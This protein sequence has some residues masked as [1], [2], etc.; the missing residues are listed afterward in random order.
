M[1]KEPFLQVSKR[2]NKARWQ[3]RLLDVY[4]RQV[5]KLLRDD[6]KSYQARAEAVRTAQIY[7]ECYA[8]ARCPSENLDSPTVIGAQAANELLN[9]AG[10]KASFV[11]TQYNNEVYISARAI[12]EVNVQ[13]MMEKMGGG[14]HMNIAGAQVKAS[15]DEV[16]SCLLY[17]SISAYTTGVNSDTYTLF[18]GPGEEFEKYLEKIRGYSEIQTDAEG[19]NI[20]DKIITLSTCTGNEATRYVVQGKRVD[21]LDVG[22]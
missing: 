15:P 2:R 19:M 6:L 12:D 14:G 7:R 18:K 10:V 4:K 21:T 17:T 20:K 1:K 11:L 16:E 5:R 8:I 13:V 22:Q 3:E 9:I